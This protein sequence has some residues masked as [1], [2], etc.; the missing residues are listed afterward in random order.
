MRTCSCRRHTW[1]HMRKVHG[2]AR[3]SNALCCTRRGVCARHYSSIFENVIYLGCDCESETGRRTND[4]SQTRRVLAR[5]STLGPCDVFILARVVVYNIVFS[6]K[7]KNRRRVYLYCVVSLT[8]R[9]FVFSH[10][11][12]P[13]LCGGLG[14]AVSVR[15]DAPP[16]SARGG[17]LEVIARQGHRC[18]RAREP[19][20]GR[21]CAG[22]GRGRRW[23]CQPRG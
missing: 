10:T 5:G 20:R 6:D 8:L 13:Y 15:V 21:P 22:R 18:Q 16:A 17:T 2:G 9:F 19:A 14:Q 12:E 7:E 23:G 1:L 11:T 4:I 3:G